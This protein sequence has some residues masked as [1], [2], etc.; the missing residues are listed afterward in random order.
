MKP[1][2]LLG[3]TFALAMFGFGT[4][5]A[6]SELNCSSGAAHPTE[7][8]DLPKLL[9]KVEPDYPSALR[10]SRTEGKVIL[11]VTVDRD[12]KVGDSTVLNCAAGRSG[13]TLDKESSKQECADLSAAAIEA[14]ERWRYTPATRNGDPVCVYYTIRIDFTLGNSDWREKK[15]I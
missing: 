8:I 14:V 4:T 12:G 6:G 3:W 15:S 9:S 13:E 2:A 5:W 1:R 11:R 7:S 10:E